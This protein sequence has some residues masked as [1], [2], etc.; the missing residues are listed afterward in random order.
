M[1]YIPDP[2]ERMESCMDDLS[3]EFD[4]LQRDVPRGSFRCPECKQ[5]RNYEPIQVT[6]SPDS[7]ACCYDCLPDDLKADYDKVFGNEN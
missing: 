6:S 3:F 2:I 1:T 7:G 4:K 5:I